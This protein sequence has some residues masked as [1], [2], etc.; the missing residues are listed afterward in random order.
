MKRTKIN[1]SILFFITL[2]F[3]SCQSDKQA[4]E[5]N[6]KNTIVKKN[7]KK[8]K[9][10]LNLSVTNKAEVTKIGDKALITVTLE[11]P[12]P[13]DSIFLFIND[14]KVATL[15]SPNLDYTFD[16]QNTKTGQNIITASLT[17][18]K[19]THK[20]TKSITLKSD[21]VPQNYGYKVIN[22]FPHDI[23]AY[24][25]GLVFLDGYFYEAT[26]LKGQSTVRKVLQ[27]TGEVI[28]GYAIPK[29]VF[30]EGICLFN[31]KI[32]QLSWQAGRGFVYNKEDFKI[33]T[34]F[35]YGTEGWGITTDHEKLFMTDG[36]NNIY[37]LEPQ[38][39]TITNTLQVY[40]NKGLVKNLNEL[41]YIDNEIY[42]NIYMTDKIARID[43]KTGKVLAYINL[44]GILPMNDYK[45]NTDVLN[46]IAYDKANKRLFVTGKKWP[47]LFEIQLVKK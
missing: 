38:S 26:G 21:I 33:E 19:N 40:D 13:N 15:I 2:F 9:N 18:N 32:I 3:I 35:S 7:A 20:V 14:K 22:V 10:P 6:K 11:N 1:Y 36:T 27:K 41:E 34:E 47:K 29:D 45:P 44:K 39:F 31:D 24:T 12:T 37:I 4:K 43:P 23:A 30:G 17:R 16:T 5:I 42:A 46:G 8:E 25:Q 28:Q